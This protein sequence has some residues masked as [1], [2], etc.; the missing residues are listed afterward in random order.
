MTTPRF[1]EGLGRLIMLLPR[2]KKIWV[3]EE[4]SREILCI[5]IGMGGKEAKLREQIRLEQ[6]SRVIKR[7]TWRNLHFL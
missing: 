5:K 4:W 7:Q 2:G 3:W 6:K 1:L